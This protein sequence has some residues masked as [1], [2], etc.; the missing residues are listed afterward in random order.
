ML[1]FTVDAALL[2]ELG[3]RLVGQPHIA[4]AELIKNSY[5]ADA[6]VVAVIFE[7]DSIEI[8]DNGHGMDPPQFEQFW[9]R[10]GSPHKANNG[11][12]PRFGRAM[13]GSKGVGRLAAQFLASRIQL[14]TRAD[15]SREA[16]RATV[17]WDEAVRASE[18]TE[19]TALVDDRVQTATFAEGSPMGTRIVLSGLHQTWDTD[20]LRGLARELWPLQPPFGRSAAGREERDSFDVQLL[21]EDLGAEREFE[22]QMG[23]VLKLWEARIRGTLNC[24]PRNPDDRSG[25]EREKNASVTIAIEFNDGDRYRDDVPLS[26]HHLHDVTFEIRVFRLHGRQQ[27]GV[28]VEPA[29]AYLRRFGGVHIYDSSFHLPYYGPDTDWLGIELDHAHRIARSRLLPD[30]L[31]VSGGLEYLPSNSRLYGVVNIDTGSEAALALTDGRDSREVLSIQVSRDRLINNAAFR[32]LRTVVRAALDYYATRAT[33][34]AVEANVRDAATLPPLEQRA[35][36][37]DDI[38]RSLEEELSE[39]SYQQL[40]TAAQAVETAVESEAEEIARN[41]GLLGALATAGISAVAYEHEAARQLQELES[42]RKRL[43]THDD[44]ATRQLAGEIGEWIKRARSTRRLFSPLLDEANDEVRSLRARRVLELVEE[45]TKTLVRGVVCDFA[46]VDPDFRLPP[47]RFSEWSALFQNVFINASNAMLDS[48]RRELRGVAHRRENQYSLVLM[49]TGTGIDLSR[50]E[51]YFQPFERDQQISP[52][53]RGLGVGG[54]GLGLTIVSML[55]RNLNCDVRFIEPPD[56]AYATAFELS[57]RN[58]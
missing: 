44:S 14:E 22:L 12:S 18:L 7:T 4:L 52:E 33:Q 2:R 13:T 11:R 53:R 34:R 9:M 32:E 49:D 1:S 51:R 43:A 48:P 42:L 45:Q 19:A 8:I 39:E 15:P 17:N 50:A 55:A 46:A 30:S 6:T 31:H 38:V 28:Q 56:R 27:F 10:I 5:D 3:E 47:G 23:A 16:M 37:F 41:V 24:N 21:A 20:A 26:I 25:E 40:V 36:R 58:Q 29:R 54:T 35:R 57:W